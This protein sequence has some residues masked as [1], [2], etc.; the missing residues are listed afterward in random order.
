MDSVNKIIQAMVNKSDINKN[1]YFNEINYK[2]NDCKDTGYILVGDGLDTVA[3]ICSC[4]KKVNSDKRIKSARM[5]KLLRCCTF[6]KFNYRYYSKKNNTDGNIS[7]YDLAEKAMDAAVAFVYNILQNKP[8][9]SILFIGKTGRGKTYLAA[10]IANEILERKPNSQLLF[11]IVPDLLNE[12]RSTY[13]KDNEI[14]EYQIIDAA[15]NA[16]ILILDDLGAHNYSD[17]VKDKLYSII[18]FRLQEQLPTVITTNLLDPP[19]MDQVLGERI[20]S[21]IFQLCKTYRIACE[22]DIRLLNSYE[23][24]QNEF[25]K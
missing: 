10:S 16:E 1:T 3:R 22:R 23:Q 4:Q 20:T 2:C 18:D 17:W 11:I 15:R 13:N 14:T 9:D 24:M 6:D 7:Y 21:R 25:N 19:A 12:I 8:T 5:S